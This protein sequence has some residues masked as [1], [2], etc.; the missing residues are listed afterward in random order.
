[1]GLVE[2]IAELAE[3]TLDG[4]EN[5]P[6]LTGSFLDCYSPETHLEGVQECGEGGGTGDGDSLLPLN[7]IEEAGSPENLR[8]EPLGGEEHDG[9]VGGVGR[10]D[11]LFSDGFCL[12]LDPPLHEAG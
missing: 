9:K 7:G 10:I 4:A 2:D 8:V 6:H 1:M 5:V 12:S 3:L 11:I